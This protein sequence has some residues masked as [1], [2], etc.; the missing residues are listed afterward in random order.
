MM[1]EAIVLMVIVVVN[2]VLVMVEM[3][4]NTITKLMTKT[5]KMISH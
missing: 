5:I 3:T 1:N 4:M 2:V